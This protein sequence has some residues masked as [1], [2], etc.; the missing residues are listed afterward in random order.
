[1]ANNE[2]LDLVRQKQVELENVIVSSGEVKSLAKRMNSVGLMSDSNRDLDITGLKTPWTDKERAGE[3]VR[4][5]MEKLLTNP[6]YFEK[7]VY[8]LRNDSRFKDICDVLKEG[9][10]LF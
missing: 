3:I 8:I 9:E 2:K 5:L 7:F 10:R 6:D 1:M 4:I